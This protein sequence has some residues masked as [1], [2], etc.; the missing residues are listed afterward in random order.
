MNLNGNGKKWLVRAALLMAVVLVGMVGART[1]SANQSKTNDYES[2]E[3]FTDVLSLV[4]KN[5]VEE[6]DTKKLIYGAINGM[7]ASLDPHSSFMPPETYKEMKIETKGSFGGLGIEITIKDGILTVIAPIEDTPAFRAGIKA[8]DH[9]LKIDDKLTKDLS[10]VEAVKRMRGTKGTK[11]TLTILREGMDKPKEFTIVRDIIQVKS[12]KHKTLDTGFGYIRIAQFQEKTSDDL[13]KALKALKEENKGKLQGLVL[14][15]RNDPGGLLDQAVKVAERFV[16][17]GKLIVYT[18]GREK[19]SKMRFVSRGGEKETGYPIVVLINSGSASASEIV[20]GA[21]Q[22]HK[23]AVIMGTQSFGKGS[24]QTIIP[25]SDDSGL[26]LTTARYFTPSGRSI[27]AKGI[28]PDITVEQIELKGVQEKK[29]GMHIREKDLENHFETDSGD[30]KVKPN[31]QSKEES[32]RLPPYKSD[33]TIR[34]DYQVL[35]ALDLLKG[36]EI[37]RKVI[38]ATG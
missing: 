31:D 6:V 32:T 28:T 2:I 18:E 15:L 1:M 29:E 33:E 36:W 8:G 12:V 27:Q 14:D 9:I 37:L 38:G 3:M 24:V 35:R 13:D 34:S 22:D 7:L 11:V 25:L 23:R 10:I 5:Y 19:D 17:E 16:D 4:K 30:G 21:L 26:R 20:A